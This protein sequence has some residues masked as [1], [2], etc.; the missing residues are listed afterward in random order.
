MSD[1]P[2]LIA[3]IEAGGTKFNCAVG[4]REGELQMTERIPTTTPAETLRAVIAFFDYAEKQ[5]GEI[6]AIG[7]GSFGPLDLHRGSKTYGHITTTP[8]PGWQHTDLLGPL[9]QRWL[10]PVGFDTDVNA[11]ALGEH[12]W[13]SGQGCDPLLYLT[14]G[15]G[16]G[17]GVLANGR[18]IHGALHPEIG[19]LHIPLVGSSAPQPDGVCPFHGS[20]LEGLISGPALA[21]RWGAPAETLPPEHACWGEFSTLLALGLVNLILTLSPRRIILGG[22]VMHQPQLFPMIREEVTRFLNGYLQCPEIVGDIRHYIVPPG[23]VDNSG[24]MGALALGISAL[25]SAGR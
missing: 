20:C 4:T 16:I 13:G 9:R 7:I 1:K 5:H 3:A 17:G 6:K 19:H 18:L 10:V 21:K 14:I 8:K 24:I 25:D 23:L 22:G 12:T 2:A 11:A 15:T